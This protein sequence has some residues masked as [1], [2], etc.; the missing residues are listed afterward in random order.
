MVRCSA[1]PSIAMEVVSVTMLFACLGCFNQVH[2]LFLS[3]F[4]KNPLP[5]C[6][7]IFLL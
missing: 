4:N 5:T 6:I 3:I 7:C 1:Y 2:L